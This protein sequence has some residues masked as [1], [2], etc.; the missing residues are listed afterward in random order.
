MNYSP[1]R[2]LAL[3]TLL[4]PILL[5]AQTPE[6]LTDF[7]VDVVADSYV[8]QVFVA[9]NLVYTANRSEGP[10]G[11]GRFALLDTESGTLVPLADDSEFIDGRIPARYGGAFQ[12][13]DGLLLATSYSSTTGFEL[14]RIDGTVVEQLTDLAGSPLTPVV[15]FG[16]SYYFLASGRPYGLGGAG[17]APAY[18]TELWQTDGTTAGTVRVAELNVLND[19]NPEENP[20]TLTAGD[21]QL[22]IAGQAPDQAV[23]VFHT[24]FLYRPADGSLTEVAV[25]AG[26]DYDR[27]TLYSQYGGEGR[28]VHFAGGFYLGGRTLGA[29]TDRPRVFRITESTASIR[30][31][32]GLL[33]Y[34]FD[35]YYDE[36]ISFAVVED[37]LYTHVSGGQDGYVLYRT[38]AANPTVFTE[39]QRSLEPSARIDIVYHDNALF[40]GGVSRGRPALLSYALRG[41]FTDRLFQLAPSS[42]VL[43]AHVADDVIYLSP[44]DGDPLLYRYDRTT[45][46]VDTFGNFAT[47][48]TGR[49]AGGAALRGD[50]LVYLGRTPAAGTAQ[51]Y[52]TPLLLGYAAE[53]PRPIAALGGGYQPLG[54]T[55]VIGADAGGAVLFTARDA[56]SAA[57]VYRYRPDDG[58]VAAVTAPLPDGAEPLTYAGPAFGTQLFT[59]Y[60]PAVGGYRVFVAGGE[61]GALRPLQDAD[62]EAQLVIEDRFELLAT[63]ALVEQVAAGGYTVYDYTVTDGVATRRD[64]IT[65]ADNYPELRRQN[66]LL[67]AGET[68][69]AG[70]AVSVI[71]SDGRVAYTLAVPRG[72]RLLTVSPDGYFL[73]DFPRGGGAATLYYGTAE[74]PAAPVALP[75]EATVVPDAPESAVQL[76]DRLFFSGYT[77]S[78]PA[79]YLADA[80][81]AT[82]TRLEGL[83]PAGP[84]DRLL[85]DG[86]LFFAATT[87]AAGTELWRTDGTPA[88]T[89]PVADLR[90]GA[91]FSA[92]TAFYAAGDT[93]YFQARGPEGTEAYALDLTD[94]EAAPER[95]TDINPGAGGSAPT[96]FLDTESGLY[97][98][99]RATDN[100]AR[101]LYRLPRITVALREPAAAPLAV[102][103]YP[104][105]ADDRL[106]VEL[107][108]DEPLSRVEVYDTGGRRLLDRPAAG[109]RHE[110]SVGQL[111]RGVYFV[112]LSGAH[113]GTVTRRVVVAR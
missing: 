56:G 27:A 95:L 39:V 93:L 98:L 111:P 86:T 97:F 51:R 21:Q 7:R 5:L 19:G 89:V 36:E 49:Y 31:L 81:A 71:G 59:A 103:V 42:G 82:V 57:T 64:L 10:E 109:H 76:G 43:G 91:D 55:A 58:T 18:Y 96:D 48:A 22:L 1:F 73:L 65:F 110:I 94:P 2:P 17:A 11:V 53:E 54:A 32:P 13:I 33:E 75:L 104:N 88:G 52:V 47:A 15:A 62:T 60:D 8:E 61:D 68:T 74:A 113:G 90:P 84:A 77:P 105:P 28:I 6:R 79:L 25:A 99:A 50:D 100:G 72:Q 101:Q 44:R 3:L 9:N 16:G 102:R 38:A 106:T 24:Y 12:S 78:G 40:F 80:A 85:V 87:A 70:E 92:P 67:L 108:G 26:Q 41:G 20:V 29:D 37:Q 30:E 112:R 14:Y 69:A 107:A 45:G 63:G 83:R 34:A 4:F 46:A 35:E 23:A 66:G